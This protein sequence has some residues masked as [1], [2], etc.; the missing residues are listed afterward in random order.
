MLV[1]IRLCQLGLLLAATL[2]AAAPA[3]AADGPYSVQAQ[4]KIGGSGWWDYLA[5]DPAT[6]LLYIT[7]GDHVVV[8]DTATGKQTADIT[9][10]KGTHGVVFDATGKVGY[11]TDG[12]SNTVAAFDRSTFKVL[13]TIPAGTGP[14]GAVFEPTTSTVWA[15]NGRSKNVTVIDTKSNK[16]TATIAL[17]G[18]PEF[19]VADGLGNVYDN[20]EDTNQIVHLDAKTRKVVG[21][22][23]IA[24]CESPSGLALDKEHSRQPAFTEHFAEN[25]KSE[26]RDQHQ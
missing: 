1:R 4:W 22:W 9:G 15:F 19:P 5:V 18:K 11:I 10:F 14:D 2:A 16:V 6:R 26:V 20:I 17:P 24:P 21:A 3:L 25:A 7:R 12:G 23:S 8:V 13:A